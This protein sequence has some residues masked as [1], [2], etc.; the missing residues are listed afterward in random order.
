MYWSARR[1]ALALLILALAS[2]VAVVLVDLGDLLDPGDRRDTEPDVT[3]ATLAPQALPAR[4]FT[5]DPAASRVDFTAQVA[6]VALNGVFPVQSGTITLEPVE[7]M[8]QVHV[9]LQID[10]DGL[11]TGNSVFDRALRGALDSGDYPLAF[12]VASSDGRVPVTEEP[13][14]F[15][16]TGDLQLHNVV[17]PHPMHVD[18]QL[19]GATLNAVAASTLD[20]ADHGVELPA[21]LGSPN[22]ELSA[23]IGAHDASESPG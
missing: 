17:Q 2:V 18:A 15:M 6:G 4:A 8:L 23:V 19:T 12:Y 3:P 5:V 11:E 16:L 22:I 13:V 9:S 7:E 14:A 20:L 10:V 21:L 1:V